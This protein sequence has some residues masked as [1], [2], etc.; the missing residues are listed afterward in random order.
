MISKAQT[1]PLWNCA[2]TK[3]RLFC[4]VAY[5]CFPLSRITGIRKIQLVVYYQCCVLIG[6]A[7]SRLYVIFFYL[8]KPANNVACDQSPFT[9]TVQIRFQTLR[10]IWLQFS[11]PSSLIDFFKGTTVIPYDQ[12]PTLNVKGFWNFICSDES[13]PEVSPVQGTL[14]HVQHSCVV[15]IFKQLCVGVTK[16]SHGGPLSLRTSSNPGDCS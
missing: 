11:W 6:W 5:Y 12:K 3:T 14:I 8:K 7:T 9:N 13:C 4:S 1:G 2:R 10:Y 15:V 16:V